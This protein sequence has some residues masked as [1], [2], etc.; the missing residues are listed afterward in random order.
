M[1]NVH[2]L[3]FYVLCLFIAPLDWEQ[4]HSRCFNRAFLNRWLRRKYLDSQQ[5]QVLFGGSIC[6][7]AYLDWQFR[8][9]KIALTTVTAC[10]SYQELFCAKTA[11]DVLHFVIACFENVG[12]I[13][14]FRLKGNLPKKCSLQLYP[15]I[16][17]GCWMNFGLEACK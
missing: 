3:M 4:L 1:E 12:K 7:E 10:S 15:E 5:G 17:W 8:M 14:Y 6:D 11:Q 2:G 13:R 9:L 16:F